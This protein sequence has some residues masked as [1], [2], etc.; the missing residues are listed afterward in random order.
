M[1]RRNSLWIVT[2]VFL[3]V[4]SGYCF[5]DAAQNGPA[6]AQLEEQ[7]SELTVAAA[8]QAVADLEKRIRQAE[9]AATEETANQL[10]VAVADL[11]ERA[12]K[13]AMLKTAYLEI[14][15]HLGKKEDLGNRKTLAREQLNAYEQRGMVRKP[16]YSLSFY[17]IQLR[18]AATADQEL[19]TTANSMDA[20]KRSLE[21]LR[22]AR[23]TLSKDL[24]AQKEKLDNASEDLEKSTLTWRSGALELERDLYDLLIKNERLKMDNL[25]TETEIGQL[26]AR[27]FQLQIAYV[28]NHL[29]F[30]PDDLKQQLDA[31]EKKQQ[32]RMADLEK[33]IQR[34]NQADELYRKA[35]A[36]TQKSVYAEDLLTAQTA[37]NTR[38]V[39]RRTYQAAIEI[40][41]ESLRL[42]AYQR[43]VWQNRYDLLK[44]DLETAKIDQWTSDAGLHLKKLSRMISTEQD[45]QASLMQQMDTLEKQ[46]AD[47]DVAPAERQQYREQLKALQ[48]QIRNRLDFAADV[49]SVQLLDRRFL[50]ELALKRGK[51]A[52]E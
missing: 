45:R 28:R 27:L 3:L 13:L 24:R 50:D 12:N 25:E 48:Q 33:L 16:P 18:E 30:D 11:R 22:Q 20:A 40:A 44:G 34:K 41:Q 6:P 23:E 49:T 15:T 42:I 51:K 1:H 37:L 46:I 4:F 36:Q 8:E 26:R 32:Q 21:D 38:E 17:D 52:P 29:H 7:P 5:S 47:N 39:W 2:A 10:G 9:Q 19:E 14:I 31:L 35:F 43:Q